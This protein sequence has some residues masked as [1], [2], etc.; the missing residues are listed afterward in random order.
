M[1]SDSGKTISIWMTTATV[2][3]QPALVENTHA[4]VCI[5]GAGIAGMSTAYMLSG[6]GKSVVVL[7]D[8]PVGGGQTERTTAHLSNVLSYRYYELEQMHGEERAKLIAES[9]TTA[10][11]TIEAIAMQENIDCD[12]V[13][14]DG[15]LFPPDLQSLDEM[16]RELAAVHRA[17][18]SNVELVK[19][20]PLEGLD[21]GACL[22]FPQQGQ[23]D[24]LKYLTG[25]VAVIERRGGRIYSNTH[26]EKIEGGA[27][28]RV[29][30]SNGQVVTA[31]AVVVATN[32]PISNVATMHFKQAAYITFVIGAK[33]PRGSVT[34][35]LYWDTLDPY[36]YVRLQNLDEQ[37]DVLIVGGEDHKTGQANDADARYANL[38]KWTQERFPMAAEI[39]FHWSGQVMN[40][41][42]GIAY[43]GKN[44]F[45]ADN[46][47]ITTGDSGLGM[48]HGTIAGILLSDMILGIKNRWAE[49]YDPSRARVGAV[50]DFISENINVASQYL[51]WVTP[52]E[53]DSVEKIAPGTAA[54]VRNGLTK[55]AAYRDE[56][57][58]L[59][60]HSAVCT[61]LNCIVSWN[62]SEQTWDCPC[63]G[64]RFDAQGK[65][66]NGPAIKALADI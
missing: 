42:D 6:A 12:F 52:G 53:V 10:I 11:N 38:Q 26:V 21:T 59:H 62:S 17:G 64:S 23:F 61:H 41:D 27:T 49:V 32:S 48:T 54:V 25:L 22:R 39:L 46:I 51:D 4:D 44:P 20:A 13:R 55:I 50:G 16:E 63:H 18:L 29:E 65:V 15:Y 7:D 5:V 58:T 2:P 57:G 43:I 35:A 19:Q 1:Q 9:H 37:H 40:A 31:D 24:P 28:A 36:H 56:S 34:Q 3:V 66:I 45:D 47:Y 60:Q 33:V 8:G 30:T 14:L